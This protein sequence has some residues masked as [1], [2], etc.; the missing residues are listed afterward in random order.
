MRSIH[1]LA[2]YASECLSALKSA[3]FQIEAAADLGEFEKRLCEAGKVA[4]HPMISPDWHDLTAANSLGLILTLDG[5]DVGGVA[6][7]FVDLG[8][9]SLA[10]YWGRS[11]RRLYADGEKT[12][13]F[14]PAP[15]IERNISKRVVYLGELF[16]KPGVR[17]VPGVSAS[18]VKYIQALSALS[19]QPDWIYG[20]LRKEDAERGKATQYG[21]TVQIPFFL[22]WTDPHQRRS[23]TDFFVANSFDDIA[24]IAERH[25]H[26]HPRRKS[27]HTGVQKES[28]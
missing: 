14:D 26:I 16:L 2:V 22:R 27:D 13:V 25:S 17:G 11:Y 19:W 12:P 3:G 8:A 1:A 9:G 24:H 23:P 20:F 18:A 7:M 10:D 28:T 15:F 4:A 6:A 21:F 5:V